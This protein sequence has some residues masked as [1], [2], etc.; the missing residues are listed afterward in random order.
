MSMCD[1]REEHVDYGRRL[2]AE[3]AGECM[4]LSAERVALTPINVIIELKT[5]K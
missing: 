5:G 4:P 1:S 2:C 3:F